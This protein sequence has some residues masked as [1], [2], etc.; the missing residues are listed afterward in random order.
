MKNLS[1][2]PKA[3][4]LPLNTQSKIK[5]LEKFKQ[6]VESFIKNN[7]AFLYMYTRIN[8]LPLIQKLNELPQSTKPPNLCDF[9]KELAFVSSEIES[10]EPLPENGVQ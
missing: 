7:G 3:D 2:R 1:I 10:N 9:K 5:R 8:L 4:V 6:S